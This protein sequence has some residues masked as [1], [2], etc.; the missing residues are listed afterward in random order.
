MTKY[1]QL[2][3]INDNILSVPTT[4]LQNG[5][6]ITYQ[7]GLSSESGSVSPVNYSPKLWFLIWRNIIVIVE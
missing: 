1:M 5:Y 7:D 6:L 4:G 3:I 2:I